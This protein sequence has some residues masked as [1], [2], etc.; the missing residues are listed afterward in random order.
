MFGI[1]TVMNVDVAVYHWL[2]SFSGR[3]PYFD[4]FILFCASYLPF[5]AAAGAISYLLIQDIQGKRKIIILL[6]ALIAVLVGRFVFTALLR[7]LINRAR[8][9]TLAGAHSLFQ[10]IGSSFPSAHATILFAGGTVLFMYNKRA[11][12]IFNIIAGIICVARV[13]AGVHYPSDIL[14]GAFVGSLSGILTVHY[15]TPF[16]AKQINSVI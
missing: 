14:V 16:L 12:I 11:G 13:V 6:D 7:L 9:Y 8:P 15:A 5:I 3:T 1:L 4:E 10:T 2:Q